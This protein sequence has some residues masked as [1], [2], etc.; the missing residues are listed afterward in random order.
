MRKLQEK[1]VEV[2]ENYRES[3]NIEEPGA[4]GEPSPSH[5][6]TLDDVNRLYPDLFK[7]SFFSSNLSLIT[8]TGTKMG[9]DDAFSRVVWETIEK[10]HK[11]NP[12]AFAPSNSS[13]R[14]LILFS[15]ARRPRAQD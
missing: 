12:H 11:V 3:N 9:V 6:E 1:V 10:W 4:N 8:L 2:V 5:V 14:F 13:N 7:E 15:A